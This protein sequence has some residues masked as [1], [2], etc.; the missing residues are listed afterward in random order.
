MLVRE[1][2]KVF[3]EEHLSRSLKNVKGRESEKR[4]P[5]TEMVVQEGKYFQLKEVT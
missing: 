5:D 3:S 1:S 2:V 4:V